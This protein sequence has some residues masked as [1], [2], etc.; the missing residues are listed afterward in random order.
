MAITAPI[1]RR[2]TNIC[3]S[4]DPETTAIRFSANEMRKA[5]EAGRSAT[6]SSQDS[7][8]P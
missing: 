3:G 1:V 8:L 5:F 6:A 7:E 4:F 2:A